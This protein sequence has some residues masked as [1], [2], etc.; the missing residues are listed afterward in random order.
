MIDADLAAAFD[1]TWPAA[2]Y[3][4]L[5]GFR[6]G[7][8]YGAG[9]RVSSARAVAKWRAEDIDAVIEASRNWAQPPMF[10]VLDD[11]TALIEAL[12]L[13]GF[14]RENPTLIMEAPIARLTRTTPPPVSS[15]DLWPPMAIQREIWAEGNIKS[16]RQ[17]VMSRVA[18]P[19]R[20]ILGRVEDR[21]AGA[22][23]AAVSHDVLMV[24]CIEVRPNLRRK[25]VA[26]WMMQ[27][28][29]HWG[30]GRGARRIALAVSQANFPAVTLYEKLG[31][32]TAARYSYYGKPETI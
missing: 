23:F 7:R 20:A 12:N 29:A 27:A 16:A 6:L 31:F 21:A 22:A 14:S 13:A 1:E 32:E 15:F 30:Q 2:E 4:D 19:R 8:G 25:S 3:A 9:G 11:D 10:R 5:G 18:V 28:A 26:E 17:A 24:H